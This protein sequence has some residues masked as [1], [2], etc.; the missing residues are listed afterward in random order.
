[1]TDSSDD[2]AFG[3]GAFLRAPAPQP[4]R[5]HPGIDWI[6][7]PA[8]LIGGGLARADSQ[9]GDLATPPTSA[10]AAAPIQAL[11][12]AATAARLSAVI[13]AVER[14]PP[15]PPVAAS[16]APPSSSSAPG[17]DAPSMARVLRAPALVD[18]PPAAKRPRAEPKTALLPARAAAAARDDHRIAAES[19]LQDEDDSWGDVFRRLRPGVAPAA[20]PRYGAVIGADDAARVVPGETEAQWCVHGMQVI[21]DRVFLSTKFKV[22]AARG[23]EH[24]WLNPTYGYFVESRWRFMHLVFRGLQRRP[25]P[26][27]RA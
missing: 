17:L 2:D 24:R 9:V 7:G 14:A 1:M 13:L 6:V 19:R 15:A 20:L 16:A 3:V 10:L 12:E 4:A 25:R 26:W 23:P 21:L 18:A 22:G 5:V 27:R 11:S 8:D